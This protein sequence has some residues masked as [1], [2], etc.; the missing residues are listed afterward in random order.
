MAR[1][2]DAVNETRRD[3]P[4]L[5]EGQLHYNVLNRLRPD[6][7]E[8]VAKHPWCDPFY[9]DE[10]LPAMLEWLRQEMAS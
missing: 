6:L 2:L 4:W 1:Y 3:E 8:W 10:R 9:H 5:R 7:A